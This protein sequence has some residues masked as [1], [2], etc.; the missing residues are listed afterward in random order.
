MG[1]HEVDIA[2]IKS[3]VGT[4]FERANAM[5]PKVN[6]MEKTINQYVSKKQRPETV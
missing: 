2:Q 3:W 4:V 5:E 6:A 1:L